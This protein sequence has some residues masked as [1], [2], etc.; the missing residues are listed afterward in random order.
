MAYKPITARCIGALKHGEF[1]FKFETD[2]PELGLLYEME[3][4]SNH[5]KKQRRAFHS[6]LNA[7]YE[8][9]ARIETF[10]FEDNGRIYDFRYPSAKDF[11]S[12]F[13]YKYG[14][15]WFEYVDDNYQTQKVKDLEDIPAHILAWDKDGRKRWTMQLKSMA[16]YTKREYK[17]IIDSLFN[18]IHATSCHDRR[19]KEIMAG[20]QGTQ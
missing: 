10:H 19:V 8:W 14:P 18:V 5:S 2:A 7:F 20:M 3:D 16:D 12:A 13:K 9:M 17:S 1:I 11:R 15:H 4:I 6:L